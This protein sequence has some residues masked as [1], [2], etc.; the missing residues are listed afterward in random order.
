MGDICALEIVI[1]T[2]HYVSE[3]TPFPPFPRVMS[4]SVPS[5]FSVHA[6]SR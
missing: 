5:V 4:F 1:R 3:E 2:A 6:I